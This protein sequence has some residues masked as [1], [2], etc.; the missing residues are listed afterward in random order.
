MNTKTTE[1][2]LM[3]KILVTGGAGYIGAHCC[4][5]LYQSGYSSIVIDNLSTGYESNVKWG[6]FIKADLAT[7]G[8]L[9]NLFDRIEI[10][11]VVHFAACAYVGESVEDPGKYYNNNLGS[12]LHLLDSMRRHRINTLVFSSTC[13]TYGNPVYTPIDELHPQSPINPYGRSKLMIEQILQDYQRAYGLRFMS[14]RY[15]NAAGADPDAEIGEQHEP[16]THLIPLA[17]DVASGKRTSIKVFGNDYPTHDGTCI[18]D[19]IHV[20]DLATAHV[21]ALQLLFDGAGSDF[22]NLGT[23]S[24]HSVYD[25]IHTA[26]KVTGNIINIDE[27][28]RRPGDPPEL[29]AA[30]NKAKVRLQWWPHFS[31]LEEII[32]TAWRWHQ[33]MD[34]N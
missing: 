30:A 9:D 31:S 17:L 28:P 14:L 23:G 10:D 12:T 1:Y 15:F 27:H 24:G 34:R 22:F 13:A 8:V 19:Y 25:V 4:K 16:E 32:D 21:K 3:K 11:A 29:I 26:E 6:D 33:K 7:P 18:R 20:S 2:A 5:I